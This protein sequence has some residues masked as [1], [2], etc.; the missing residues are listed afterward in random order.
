MRLKKKEKRKHTYTKIKTKE[1]REIKEM[2]LGYPRFWT[3][4]GRRKR[5]KMGM[6]SRGRKRDAQEKAVPRRNTVWNLSQL[7][8]RKAVA[9]S[10][11]D[12]LQEEKLGFYTFQE[13]TTDSKAVQRQTVRC[14]ED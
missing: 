10:L 9:T 14:I 2:R 5:E 12:G 4:R 6:G 7:E 13:V 3:G 8:E 11:G 1:K